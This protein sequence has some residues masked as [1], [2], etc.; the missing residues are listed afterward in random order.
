MSFFFLFFSTSFCHLGTSV[1]V[2]IFSLGLVYPC[3][4]PLS[5]DGKASYYCWC[6]AEK[7]SPLFHLPRFYSLATHFS[8]AFGI[9]SF[10]LIWSGSLLMFV[11]LPLVC[12][13]VFAVFLDVDHIFLALSAMFVK[14]SSELDL[15]FELTEKCT[16]CKSTLILF[17][18]SLESYA[19]YCKHLTS[20]F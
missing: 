19:C 18:L 5:P 11:L 4:P 14:H 7:K 8:C 17:Y 1:H 12:V 10:V 15:Y 16:K 6:S 9:C 3:C 20:L 13:S 2:T